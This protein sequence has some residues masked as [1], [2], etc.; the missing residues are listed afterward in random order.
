[1]DTEDLRYRF[2]FITVMH[3]CF[4][5]AITLFDSFTGCQPGID[6][7]T[8]LNWWTSWIRSPWRMF[9]SCGALWF[10]APYFKDFFTRDS[11]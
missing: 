5:A 1:M 4:G 7:C 8:L 11:E 3:A 10:V 6:R 2:L 9:I